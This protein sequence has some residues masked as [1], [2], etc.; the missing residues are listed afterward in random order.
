MG[1]SCEKGQHSLEWTNYFVKNYF[2]VDSTSNFTGNLRLGLAPY[3]GA[4][5]GVYRKP[6]RG[7]KW[8][9]SQG[10]G[11][12]STGIRGAHVWGV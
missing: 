12:Q 5:N 6:F 7:V 4:V 9:V 11:P 2:M 3:L 1:A 10:F 8:F